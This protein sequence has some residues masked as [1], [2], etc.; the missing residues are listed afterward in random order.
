M[1]TC[2]NGLQRRRLVASAFATSATALALLAGGLGAPVAS[3][4]DAPYPPSPLND[5][6]VPIP[7][8]QIEAAIAQLDSVAEDL[9]ARTE[10]P[11]MAIA[12]VH[13][14]AV[15]YTK[16][17]GV[18]EVGTD[19][20]VD[21]NTVFQ[22][23]SVSK[24]LGG[25]AVARAVSEGTVR[26]NDP[27]S[28]YLPNF[29]LSRPSTT[30]NVTIA[31][32]FAH[33]SGL[34]DHL[35]DIL[36]DLGSPRAQILRRLRYAPLTPLRQDY[37]YSNYGLTA[38]GVAVAKAAG[39]NWPDFMRYTLYE[40]LG[41][42]ST[43]SRFS[44]FEQRSNRATLHVQNEDGEWVVGDVRQPDPQA[45][46]GGVSSTVTDLA[47][48]LRLVLA[49][50]VYDGERLVRAR[51]LTAMHT[52]AAVVSPP[53]TP[54]DRVN[55]TGLGIDISVDATGRVRWAHSGAFETGA[56]TT[57]AMLPS[58]RLGIVVL[59]NGWPI[60]V[61]EA[62]AAT[63]LDLAEQGRVTFDWLSEYAPL[64][65]AT[66]ANTSRLF[67]KEQPA[68]PAPAHGPSFYT[69]T[70]ENDFYGRIQVLARGEQLTLV[71]GREKRRFA[72]PHWNRNTFS[73]DWVGENEYGI[74]AV[75]FKPGSGGHAEAVRIENLD[76]SGL[77][78][79]TRR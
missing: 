49:D 76:E 43:S 32:L 47:Q 51:A 61:P 38:A 44:D 20:P 13:D 77:G 29:V 70:Y 11:G 8:G 26:W 65:D 50:G 18:R 15:V 55:T 27:V 33:R 23:A 67:G 1:T 30:K 79:F 57:V 24:P 40:P 45:P 68:D 46:A 56:S 74:S 12:V 35:G 25:T 39:T 16:G 64:L 17:F 59:T 63:F 73:Y 69:G 14:D 28:K 71:L 5:S 53:Q 75:D 31:D 37:A 48:W 78:S 42:T 6:A 22:L 21:E 58:E 62:V 7:S 60:G 72:L 54:A 10:V 2:A 36:E 4:Q 3:A 41:M 66:R 34:P 52:P 9:Q 19:Q